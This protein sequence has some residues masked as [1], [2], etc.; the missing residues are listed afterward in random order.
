MT[1]PQT[2]SAHA[3]PSQALEFKGSRLTVMALCVYDMNSQALED[4]LTHKVAQ[5]PGMFKQ[6]PVLIDLQHVQDSTVPLDVPFLV[7]QLRRHGM[8][9]VGIR[10]GSPR[11]QQLA[12]DAGLSLL[13]ES[14]VERRP[15]TMRP[16]ADSGRGTDLKV[17]TQP[18]RSGQQ[19]VAKSGD[20]VVLSMVSAGAEILA[21][22]S[23]HVYGALRG[24]ALA[25]VTGDTA[26]RIFCQE[27]NAELVA[28]AGQ[29]QVSED[30]PEEVRGKPAQV[31]LQEDLLKIDV[32]GGFSH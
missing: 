32:F 13:P 26:A 19:V 11:Q 30:Y 17:V 3:N 31:Y 23:I 15:Q 8:I 20:L 22:G 28:V 2:S 16:A 4:Q 27:F 25:G 29:Y 7:R 5:A 24:R 14:K 21:A 10:G 12:A 18:V 6:A 9:P 1:D